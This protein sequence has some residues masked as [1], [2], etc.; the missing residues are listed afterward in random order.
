MGLST[1]S[2]VHGQMAD[3][4]VI[5]LA[6]SILAYCFYIACGP[7]GIGYLDTSLIHL[8]VLDLLYPDIGID[9]LTPLHMRLK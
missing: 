1:N 3:I 9:F 7:N 8:L 6:I 4:L 2:W 5:S